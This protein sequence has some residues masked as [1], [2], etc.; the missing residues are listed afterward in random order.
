MIKGVIRKL[1]SKTR[2]DSGNYLNQD[3]KKDYCS[4]N[5]RTFIDMNKVEF[6]NPGV[7]RIF[8]EVGI[9]SY[10]DASII[11]ETNTGKISIG[12]RTFIGG[13]LTMIFIHLIGRTERMTLVILKKAWRKVS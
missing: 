9:D 12:D 10:V 1:F 8:L 4:I 6:R 5:E 7:K 11:F 13:S 3:I 2:K